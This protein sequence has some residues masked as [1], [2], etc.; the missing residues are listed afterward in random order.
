M[1]LFM[2]NVLIAFI[3]P[4]VPIDTRSSCSLCVPVTW[5]DA[6]SLRVGKQKASF[7]NSNPFGAFDMDTIK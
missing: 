7:R 1:F 6:I 4:I 3:R 2:S 5:G